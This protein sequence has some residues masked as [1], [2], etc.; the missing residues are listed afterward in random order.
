MFGAVDHDVS[1]LEAALR[2]EYI[3]EGMDRMAYDA[4]NLGA[5]DLRFGEDF[6]T[7][8]LS[9]LGFDSLS[10]NLVRGDGSLYATSSVI[11]TAGGYRVGVVGVVGESWSE[12]IAHDSDAAGEALTVSPAAAAVETA[13]AAVRDADQVVLLAYMSETEAVALASSDIDVIVAAGDPVVATAAQSL[14]DTWFVRVGTK[15]KAVVRLDLV[16]DEGEWPALDSQ[17]ITLDST[18]PDQPDQIALYDQYL[19][20]LEGAAQEIVD[21]MD[22]QVPVGGEYVGSETCAVCHPEETEQW[23]TTPH[24]R[25]FET[26][27]EANHDYSPSCYTC[28]TVGFGFTGGFVLPEETPDRMD[29]GCENCHGA[30]GDHVAS[31]AAGDS[32]EPTEQCEGCHTEEDSPMFSLETYLPVVRH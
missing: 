3:V 21:S 14:G 4:V 8:N 7:E 29:V 31:P 5:T 17:V 19:I 9:G 26:L 13:V 22:I 32:L 23:E 18:W 15:G 12:D 27:V 2:A 28:H 30:G 10:A 1:S 20:D 25:A 24:A 16:D 11:E 6:L